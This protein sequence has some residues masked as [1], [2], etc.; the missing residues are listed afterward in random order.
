MLSS[1][2]LLTS[3]SSARIQ[4]A[5]KSRRAHPSRIDVLRLAARGSRRGRS[6][7]GFSSRR[8]PPIITNQHIYDKIGVSTRAAAASGHATRSRLLRWRPFDLASAVPG[9]R[10]LKITARPGRTTRR[11]RDTVADV[12]PNV[13]SVRSQGELFE[14]RLTFCRAATRASR[15]AGRQGVT[16][17][18]SQK[19]RNHAK[20]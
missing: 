17:V 11:Y 20:F 4:P 9:E 14:K 1:Q 2:H 7:I 19:S 10:L 15:L 5:A 3:T 13:T 18:A 16:T 8:R 12:T 6:L